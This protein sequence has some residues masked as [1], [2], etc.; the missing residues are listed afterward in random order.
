MPSDFLPSAS[1]VRRSVLVLAAWILLAQLSAC[2]GFGIP[3]KQPEAVEH[4]ARSAL[5][6][7]PGETTRAEVRAAFGEPWLKS[8]FWDF[9]LY[10]TEDISRE[11]GVFVIVVLPLPVGVFTSQ[12]GGYV[13]IAYDN[14][15]RIAQV[16]L[17][18]LA[19]NVFSEE[20]G[21]LRAR[22]I[23][24]GI[25]RIERRG[26]VLTADA[27][28][29]PDYLAARGRT[30]TC[31]VVVSCDEKSYAKWPY[32]TCPDRV[33]IDNAEPFDARPFFIRCDPAGDCPP[34][35]LHATTPMRWVPTVR[36]VSL[37]PG[38]HR[39]VMTS[40]TFQG[41]QETGFEC[42]AGETQYAII[43]GHVD[44]HWWSPR[45]ST[46]HTA[47]TFVREL[48]AGWESRSVL[49][50]SRDGWVAAPEPDRP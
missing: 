10:R 7:R 8:G 23:T 41:R 1:F 11:I 29:L 14:G 27:N 44:W 12:V 36:P 43:G 35:S 16:S 4:Q 20:F 13:L 15:A 22:D 48:P 19:D 34:G 30:G 18:R 45:T 21:T 33:T 25:E 17:D 31:T 46:L 5:E 40:S 26:A 3:L 50:Y 6:L 28:R 42:G 49:L 32:E 2:G 24:F 39:L 9:D 37:Q 47:V 38:S